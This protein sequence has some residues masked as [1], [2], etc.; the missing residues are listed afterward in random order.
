MMPEGRTLQVYCDAA[1]IESLE[2][3]A[4]NEDPQGRTIEQL[5]EAAVAEAARCCDSRN[6][7]RPVRP[8]KAG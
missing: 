3:F 2:W 6:W 8:A 7:V 4:A 5:A 1:T